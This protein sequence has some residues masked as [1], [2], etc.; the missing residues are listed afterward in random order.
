MIKASTVAAVHHRRSLDVRNLDSI[1]NS[2][3]FETTWRLL[4]KKEQ[5]EFLQ[6]IRKVKIIEIKS[7]INKKMETRTF[8]QLRQIA[9]DYNIKNYSRKSKDQLI[10]EIEKRERR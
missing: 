5:I 10:I 6:L 1:I 9:R 8:A 7:I 4:S 3:D 2:L